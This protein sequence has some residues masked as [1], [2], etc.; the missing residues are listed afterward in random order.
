MINYF[1]R[2]VHTPKRGQDC[3]KIFMKLLCA[4]KLRRNDEKV[5]AFETLPCGSI[6][7]PL[8][9]H[10]QVAIIAIV[11]IAVSNTSRTTITVH[12]QNVG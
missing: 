1:S 9:R 8:F 11:I 7:S 5:D 2:F 3:Y 10:L 12:A 6:K 4:A